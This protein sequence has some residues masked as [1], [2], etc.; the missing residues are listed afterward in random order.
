[1]QISDNTYQFDGTPRL[2]S[3]LEPIAFDK[4][5]YWPGAKLFML[6]NSNINVAREQLITSLE[7]IQKSS[8]NHDMEYS[9]LIEQI[10]NWSLASRVNIVIDYDLARYSL[11]N[12]PVFEPGNYLLQL[13][14]PP[15]YVKIFGA[16]SNPVNKEYQNNTCV[17]ELLKNIAMSDQAD[18]S[19]VYIIDGSGSVKKAPIAYWNRECVVP[20]R[21]AMIYVPLQEGQYFTQNNDLNKA[22]IHL[23]INRI[24]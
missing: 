8:D 5:W 3:V 19:I 20:K 4:N 18:K 2:S 15:K 22:I 13:S 14:E 10:K 12:N 21:G 1:V 23:A 11:K 6:N 24:D 9:K 17:H 7:N 16:V